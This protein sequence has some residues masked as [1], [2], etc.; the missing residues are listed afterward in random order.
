MLT[1]YSGQKGMRVMKTCKDNN[2]TKQKRLHQNPNFPFLYSI[3]YLSCK[4]K[5]PF[6][7]V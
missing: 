6:Y 4:N 1:Q 2:K 5:N 3:D 7:I